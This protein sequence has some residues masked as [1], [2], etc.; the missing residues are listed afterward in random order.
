MTAIYKPSN[1]EKEKAE[2]TMSRPLKTIV[3]EW[4]I[5]LGIHILISGAVCLIFIAIK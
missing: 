1:M 5:G 2:P 4:Y 3:K